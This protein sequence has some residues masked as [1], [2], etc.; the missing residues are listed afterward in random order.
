MFSL[1]DSF[2]P[3]RRSTL[4][5][6]WYTTRAFSHKSAP[7][8]R[9]RM[10]FCWSFFFR[11]LYFTRLLHSQGFLYTTFYSFFYTSNFFIVTEATNNWG[12]FEHTCKCREQRDSLLGANWSVARATARVLKRINHRE[13][14]L[15]FLSENEFGQ[16]LTLLLNARLL[17]GRCRTVLC[18]FLLLKFELSGQSP[19]LLKWQNKLEN[20]LDF[21]NTEVN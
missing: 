20:G 5:W 12:I 1:D 15:I 9:N 3:E 7:T 6:Q 14:E 10:A 18:L 13:A 2:H 16:A 8:W 4:L 17:S 21:L 19:L 11:L